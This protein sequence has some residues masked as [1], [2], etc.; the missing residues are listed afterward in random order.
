MSQIKQRDE[1]LQTTYDRIY[2]RTL[3]DIEKELERMYHS[4]GQSIG[5]TAGQTKV[6]ASE[7][8]MERFQWL[9]KAWV[10]KRLRDNQKATELMRLYNFSLRANRLELFK[11]TLEMNVALMADEEEQTTQEYILKEGLREYRNQAGIMEL[12]VPEPEIAHQII[13]RLS[14]TSFKGVTWSDRVWQRQDGLSKMVTQIAE[15][16]VLMGRS[17]LESIPRLREMFNV[18]AYEARRLAVTES[19][20]VQTEV[21]KDLYKRND[22][23]EYIYLAEPTACLICA[24]LHDKTFKVDDMTPGINA[25]PMHPHCRCSTAP[26]VDKERDKL[27]EML[28][29]RE[30]QKFDFIKPQNLISLITQ[31]G[32]INAVEKEIIYDKHDGYIQTPNSFYINRAMRSGKTHQLPTEKMKTIEVLNNVIAKNELPSNL[33][34]VRYVDTEALGSIIS[35]NQK[36]FVEV[37]N[38]NDIVDVLN[39]SE[40]S[41]RD[42][43]FVSVSLLEDKN[44]FKNNR[45]I[46]LV[47]DV[48]KKTNVFVTENMMESEMIIRPDTRYDIIKSE[49]DSNQ[50]VIYMVLKE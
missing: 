9:A 49:V 34:T 11:A 4:F 32:K 28:K 5:K 17:P 33:R 24:S 27:E 45:S 1:A 47:I 16:V 38:I 46:K 31:S 30:D 12:T 18:G 26:N 36:K 2:Q 37:T 21:Q 39:K 7:L 13:N 14:H 25:C 29:E 10:D 23:D 20:R 40:I 22:F 44:V 41:F 3:T 19:A 6:L 15:D 8:E 50:L 35:Q 43:G 42:Q 48:P